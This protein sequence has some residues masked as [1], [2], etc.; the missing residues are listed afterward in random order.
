MDE[1]HDNAR[2]VL[3]WVVFPLDGLLIGGQIHLFD[4]LLEPQFVVNQYVP[5]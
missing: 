1:R 3:A 4:V 5:K 2:L